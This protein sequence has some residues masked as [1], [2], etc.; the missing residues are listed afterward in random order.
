MALGAA[1][2]LVIDDEPDVGRALAELLGSMP[3]CEA[4]HVL[5]FVEGLVRLRTEPWDLVISDERLRDGSGTDL[6]AEAAATRP[7][8]RR[9]LMT[10]YSDHA[11]PV[12]AINKARADLF[13]EKPWEPAALLARVDALL[14][15]D[16]TL[17]T[18][19]SPVRRITPPEGR[20]ALRLR[21][22]AG[23]GSVG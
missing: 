17:A 14:R 1:R 6:L 20:A 18:K 12:G 4:L 15:S 11:I 16:R 13:I 5:T 7:Q 21:P 22:S 2:I 19:A 9:A 10:A 23:E 8:T 3:G